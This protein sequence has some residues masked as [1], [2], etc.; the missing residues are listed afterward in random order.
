MQSLEALSSITPALMGTWSLPARLRQVPALL[1]SLVGASMGSFHIPGIEGM[2]TTY[3]GFPEDEKQREARIAYDAEMLARLRERGEPECISYLSG[4]IGMYDSPPLYRSIILYPMKHS[5]KAIAWFIGYDRR[6]VTPLDSSVFGG[7][8]LDLMKRAEEIVIPILE[9]ER[10]GK[11]SESGAVSFDELL[12]SNQKILLERMNEEIERAERYHHGFI[13]T[14]FRI[15]GLKGM[16]EKDYHRT[17]DLINELSTGVRGQVR[18]TDYFSWIE[19]DIFAVISL[20]SQNR[21]EYLE[22]RLLAFIEKALRNRD[23]YDERAFYP[24]SA[25]A[26]FPGSCDS[27]VELI[28]DARHRL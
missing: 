26:V 27:A 13:V 3:H 5:G 20:E 22:R 12:K 25:F 14:L 4:S 16:M 23:L 24:S 15:N 2:E 28:R 18:K 11:E 10:S 8:E 7:H 6:P 9:G 19:A 17:L 1:S 21:I